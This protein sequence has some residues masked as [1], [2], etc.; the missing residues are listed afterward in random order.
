[1]SRIILICKHFR[2]PLSIE[3]EFLVDFAYD[4]LTGQS[5]VVPCSNPTFLGATFDNDLGEY[6]LEDRKEIK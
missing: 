5:V 1:M 3:K 2:K 4:E 6:V